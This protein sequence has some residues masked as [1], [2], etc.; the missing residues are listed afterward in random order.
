[1]N[2]EQIIAATKNFVLVEFL[3][4]EDARNLAVDTPLISSGVL[5][6]ISRLKLVTFL[7]D[8]YGVQFEAHE[9]GAD[10]LETLSDIADVVMEKKGKAA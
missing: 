1:M 6:S 10:Y 7:E 2:K 9:M 8:S 4:G 5:D 3:P